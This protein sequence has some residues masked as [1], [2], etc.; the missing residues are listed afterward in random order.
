MSDLEKRIRLINR[1][2]LETVRDDI[3]IQMRNQGRVA[4]MRA[5]RSLRVFDKG[6]REGELRGVFYFRGLK[7]QVG[8]KPRAVSNSLVANIAAWMRE[9]SIQPR[10]KKG[11]FA[12]KDDASRTRAAWAI[13][14]SLVKKGSRIRQRRERG[15]DFERPIKE[16]M[17][18]YLKEIG[19]TMSLDFTNRL[20]IK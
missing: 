5:I 10:G 4:S 15:L 16:N 1:E 14:K 18:E 11:R 20:K 8:V 13:A 2:Y 12:K 3:R 9:K 7:D 6:L 19:K 17:P